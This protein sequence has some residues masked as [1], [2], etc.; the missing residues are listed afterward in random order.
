MLRLIHTLNGFYDQRPRWAGAS[1]LRCTSSQAGLLT[2]GHLSPSPIGNLDPVDD[3]GSAG[4]GA[5]S[6]ILFWGWSGGVIRL[7]CLTLVC[8]V[9][10]YRLVQV[11]Q[12]LKK[13]LLKALTEHKMAVLQHQIS[14]LS[15]GACPRT[16]LASSPFGRGSRTQVYSLCTQVKTDL[17]KTL[18]LHFDLVTTLEFLP[19]ILYFY[20]WREGEAHKQRSPT[21][22]RSS[23]R[24]FHRRGGGAEVRRLWVTCSGIGWQ[25]RAMVVW[26]T[27]SV[28]AWPRA[29]LCLAFQWH[30]DET[31]VDQT[32]MFLCT[33]L[34]PNFDPLP[35]FFYF[36]L[37]FLCLVFL[38]RYWKYW[39]KN[40]TTKSS[41]ILSKWL[42][43]ARPLSIVNQWQKAGTLEENKINVGICPKLWRI[44]RHHHKL[45]PAAIN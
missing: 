10:R 38:F 14:K 33:P 40:Y 4:E 31:I 44:E 18:I 8:E 16:P 37:A 34:Q 3:R 23:F 19:N 17:G 25:W 12:N 21:L 42:K 35:I 6:A 13:T 22:E 39:K 26:P 24:L 28:L 5:S 45:M 41:F 32:L 15:G 1:E 43:M 30:R 11:R 36:F 9:I 29:A 2:V 27:P 20:N 7:T